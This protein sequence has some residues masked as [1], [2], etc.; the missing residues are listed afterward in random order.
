MTHRHFISG[1]SLMSFYL[2]IDEKNVQDFHDLK[3]REQNNDFSGTES[4]E[5]NFLM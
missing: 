4:N 3:L 2:D 5:V 1:T